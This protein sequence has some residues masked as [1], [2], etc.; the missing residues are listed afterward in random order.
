M[1]RYRIRPSK[2]MRPVGIVFSIL[3]VVVACFFVFI[4]VTQ[5]IPSGAGGFGLLWTGM[6]ACFAIYGVYSLVSLLRHKESGGLYGMEIVDE[7]TASGNAV[8]SN[9][10]QRLQ[11]LRR[12]YDQSLITEEEYEAKR[13]EILKEL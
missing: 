9:T 2:E 3:Y 12:L 6:A 11:E 8:S 7:S 5:L 1:R 10:E 13:Q 4:G